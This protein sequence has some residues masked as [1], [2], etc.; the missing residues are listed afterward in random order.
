MYGQCTPDDDLN[1]QSKVV[2]HKN[3]IG[4]F[5]SDLGYHYRPWQL[6]WCMDYKNTE[7]VGG[8]IDV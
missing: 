1:N 4:G 7:R 3:D 8:Y 2:V 5:L 6:Q